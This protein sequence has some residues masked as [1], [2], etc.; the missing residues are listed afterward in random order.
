MLRLGEHARV[1]GPPEL[2]RELAERV[3]LLDERH[4]AGPDGAR[5]ALELAPPVAPAAPD[6]AAVAARRRDAPHGG[7]D[8]ARSASRGS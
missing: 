3:E 7:G 4:R 1:L 2:E 6:A 8:P 5:P